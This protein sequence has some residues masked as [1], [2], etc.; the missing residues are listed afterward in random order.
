[1]YFKLALR[2]ARRSILDYLLYIS[3]M[4]VLIGVMFISNC[5]ANWGERR[6]GF[7]TISLPLLIVLVMV[8]LVNYIHRFIVKQRAKEFAV[9][10]LLGME[11]N[12]LSLM[13]LCELCLIGV[14][15]F[16]L[17]V[18][19]GSGIYYAYFCAVLWGGGSQSVLEIVRISML[20]TFGYFCFVEA[21]SIFCLMKNI[22]TL[23]IIELMREKQH[24]QPL[25]AGKKSFWCKML[26]TSFL[27]F[28]ILLI[29]ISFLSDKVMFA[30]V[31]IIAIPML[32]CVFSFYKWLYAFFAS[33]R[34]SQADNLYQGNRLYRIAQMTT[35]SKTSAHINAV[36]CICLIFSAVSFVFGLLLLNPDLHIF[37]HT[38]QQWMGFL[39]IAICIIFL[40]IYFSILSLLHMMD[41]KREAKSFMLLFYMGKNQT[42]LKILLRTQVLI[43]LFLPTLMSFIMLWLATPLIN[44]K[45]NFMLP[46]PMHNLLL[47]AVC[48]FML[49]FFVLYSC[50]FCVIYMVSARYI[51]IHA[52]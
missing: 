28:L 44:Y 46:L 30:A 32:L 34:L 14:I 38:Q 39:Q 11:K 24:N 27:C 37:E 26:V 47:N 23:Q 48:C 2:N 13:F 5:M 41:Q 15:C 49:C 25:E 19:F 6:A 33:M 35:T 17:G 7:Q 3:S 40:V 4:V 36:F 18:L 9:Y 50:Y 22:N 42:E 52:R 1:M 43:K 8:V 31:S 21:L 12:T 45:L 10:M 16:V 51:K 20:Q 29:G